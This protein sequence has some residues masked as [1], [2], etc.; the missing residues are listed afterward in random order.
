MVKNKLYNGFRAFSVSVASNIDLVKTARVFESD[1]WLYMEQIQAP[2][3]PFVDVQAGEHKISRGMIYL[4]STFPTPLFGGIVYVVVVL[5]YGTFPRLHFKSRLMRKFEFTHMHISAMKNQQ[6]MDNGHQLM[7]ETD[8]AIERS[9]KVVH[10]TV[11]VG[12][13][14]AAALKAQGV[15]NSVKPDTIAE[16]SQP[17]RLKQV[18]T[19]IFSNFLHLVGAVIKFEDDIVPIH[20]KE[21]V[22][23]YKNSN[24]AAIALGL[25]EQN[26]AV[27]EDTK[28]N[29]IVSDFDMPPFMTGLEL[30]V[31]V[32]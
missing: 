19:L 29:L 14:T 4:H 24:D 6:L 31:K 12:T 23:G 30:L 5:F 15:L 16:Y 2:N 3:A 17:S 18:Y 27:S 28:P 11:N 9:K 7:D 10:E 1:T 8:Q 22:T 25:D 26:S 13:K 32:K 21:V 20:D